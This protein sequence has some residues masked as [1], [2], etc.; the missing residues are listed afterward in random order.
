M[1]FCSA[2]SELSGSVWP[3]QSSIVLV[4]LVSLY[5]CQKK[6]SQNTISF[7]L[8]SVINHANISASAVECRDLRVKAHEVLK[9]A[10]SLLFRRNCAVHQV[11]KAGI[12]ST[13]STFS[14]FYPRYVSHRHLNT[15][16]F[17]S[18]VVAQQVM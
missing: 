13:H 7:W 15:L 2:P 14:S 11:L 9:V 4:F 8:W 18:V 3:E 16:S 10:T 6:V 17:G 5:L 1:S 12:W